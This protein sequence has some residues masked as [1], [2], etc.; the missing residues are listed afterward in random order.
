MSYAISAYALLLLC[1]ANAHEELTLGPSVPC[2]GVPSQRLSY[3]AAARD[4]VGLPVRHGIRQ[5]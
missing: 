5:S 2:F 1:G 4:P 3:D